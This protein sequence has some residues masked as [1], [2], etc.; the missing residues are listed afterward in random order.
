MVGDDIALQPLQEPSAS[1][2]RSAAGS[3]VGP[4]KHQAQMRLIEEALIQQAFEPFQRTRRRER[5][6]AIADHFAPPTGLVDRCLLWRLPVRVASPLRTAHDC[7]RAIHPTKERSDR[8]GVRLT[9]QLGDQEATEDVVRVGVD[10]ALRF[11][12]GRHHRPVGGHEAAPIFR[13]HLVSCV[14]QVFRQ[15]TG[16]P[17]Q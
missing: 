2:V 6:V 14:G 15:A 1:V 3:Q 17:Q 10:P 7:T 9:G 4:R 8:F 16:V 12:E 11:A 5:H 13:Y